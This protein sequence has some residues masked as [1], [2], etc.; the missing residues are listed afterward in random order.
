MHKPEIGDA[1]PTCLSEKI[2]QNTNLPK[3]IRPGSG[4]KYTAGENKKHT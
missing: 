3:C 1:F 4:L 2:K